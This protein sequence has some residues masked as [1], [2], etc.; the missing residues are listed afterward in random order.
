[1]A[2]SQSDKLIQ[3]ETGGGTDYFL[4]Q[5]I[6][7]TQKLSQPYTYQIQVLSEHFD[8]DRGSMVGQFA[9]LFVRRDKSK[10]E[11]WWAFSGFFSNF[12]AGKIVKWKDNP[13]QHGS[14]RKIPELREYGGMLVPWFSLLQQT[15]DCRI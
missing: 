7:G 12:Y 2:Y 15:S 5:S 13:N 10:E 11:P 14:T 4:L 8:V 9:K 3:I 6:H 1:M